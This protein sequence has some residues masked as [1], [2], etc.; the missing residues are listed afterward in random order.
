VSCASERH[1]VCILTERTA[2]TRSQ[3]VYL[4]WPDLST[5]QILQHQGRH[6]WGDFSV[7]N[8]AFSPQTSPRGH[9]QNTVFS[10]EDEL[11]FFERSFISSRSLKNNLVNWLNF[12]WP[13]A[14]TEFKKNP[15]FQ[16][17]FWEKLSCLLLKNSHP[18]LLVSLNFLSAPLKCDTIVTS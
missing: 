9:A 5:G 8:A 17:T 7:L 1:V 11:A 15:V 13:L 4:H 18:M 6:L 3:R 2:D 14:S 16:E 12:S 10:Y